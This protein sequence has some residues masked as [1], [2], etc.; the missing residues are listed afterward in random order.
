MVVLQSTGASRCHNCCID[1]DTSPEYVGYTLV[2]ASLMAY[3]ETNLPLNKQANELLNREG[4]TSC[5]LLWIKWNWVTGFLD[6]L[7]VRVSIVITTVLINLS[8]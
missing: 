2:L 4:Q 6:V 5:N 7:G 1:G 3:N 8:N